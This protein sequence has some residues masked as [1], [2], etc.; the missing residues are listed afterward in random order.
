MKRRSWTEEVLDR[1]NPGSSGAAQPAAGVTFDKGGNLYGTTVGGGNSGSGTIFQLAPRSNGK[2]IESVLYRFQDGADGSEP[3]GGV[4]F[5]SKGNL[6]GTATG[7]GTVGGGTIFRLRPGGGSW[8][9]TS[10]YDFTGAPDGSYP[11]GNLTLDK[12]GNLYGTTQ[13]SGTG[14]ACGNYG[15]GTVF[16]V[17][18]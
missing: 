2:W 15:C 3:R 13:Q 1:F 18:P 12:T 4:V 14:Q 10:L 8:S 11:S 7:G 5:D 6:Y 9:F 17:W 16:E